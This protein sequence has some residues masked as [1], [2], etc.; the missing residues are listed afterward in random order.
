MKHK[1]LR[2]FMVC[3]FCSASM[4][5]AQNKTI[6]G[7]VTSREDGLPIPGATVKIQGT[8]SGGQTNSN[9][10]Y[11]LNV[12]AGSKLVFSFIGYTTQIIT[13]GT[14]TT[15]DV[16]LVSDAKALTEVVVTANAIVREKRSL[17]YSA[18]TVKADEL[19]QGGSSS[20]ISAL[21]GRVA[22][23]NI[24]SSSSTPGSSSRI[25]LRGGS[26]ISGNNQ[27]LIVV[28]GLPIDNSSVIGGG[29]LSS[30]DFGNRGNDINPDDIAS[31]TVLKGPAAAALYGSR[32]SNGALIITTKTGNKNA[33][34]TAITFNSQNTF[35]SILKLP[36]FQNEYGQGYYTDINDDGTANYFNDP[37]ENGS[38]GAP[39]TGKVQPWGQEIDGVQ[40]TKAYSAIKN[41]I[42]DFFTTGYAADNN[43]TFSGGT[44]KSTF[45]LGLNAVNSNGILPGNS[46]KFNKYGVRFNGNTNFSNKF[47][48][49]ISVN[50]NKTN[51]N[52][53]AGGQN[54]SS[55]YN[56]LL[57]TPRD[58]PITQLKDLNNKYNSFGGYVDGNGVS[59]PNT[60]GYYGAYTV[61]PYWVIQ[62]YKNLDDLS[63]IT[64]NVNLGY[65]P[66]SW[67]N[68]VERVGIDSYSER[69][70]FIAPKYK[71]TPLDTETGNYDATGNLQTSNGSYEIDQFNVTE[72]VH[73]LMITASHK[74]NEDFNGSFM[75]GNNIRQR[76]TNTTQTS[77]NTSNGLVVPDWYNLA[78]SNGPVNVITDNI[79]KQRLVGLYADLNLSYKSLIFLEA[80]ARND[81]SST[82]PVA[83]NSF[84]YP[85][86]SGS[87]VFSELLKGTGVDNVISYGK[88]R[89]SWAQV[90]NDTQPYQLANTF[91]R[92]VVNGSF[93]NTTFPF[94][95]V[96]A[97]QASNLIGNATLKPEK[98]SSFE[99]GTEL[100]FL[101]GRISADFSYYKNKSKNQILA[102]P[103]P[104]STG[105]SFAVVNAGEIQNRGVEASLRGTVVKTNDITWELFATYTKNNSK[106][107]SLLPG[108][109]QV[110]VGGFN[111]MS[112]VAAVG[113]PYGEFYAVTDQKD[114]Q[115]RTV[116]GASTGLPLA[117]AKAQYLGS[118]NPNY[119][120]SWGSNFRFKQLSLNVLFDTKQGGKLYSRTKDIIGFNGTSAETGGVRIGAIF[121]NS[122]YLQNGT[123]V[124]NTD[125]TYNKQDLYTSGTN[126][127]VNII[128]ATYIKLRSAALSYTFTKRQLG[129]SPFGA[130]TIGLYG[131]NLFLWT[132]K[133]NKF[134]DPEVN[135]SGAG[136]AQGFDFSAQPS[137]RNYGINVKVSF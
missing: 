2:I 88:L 131:N 76:E 85:S 137:V 100:G 123:Y 134:V 98:T 69:R 108:I 1:L 29:T 40:Q 124:P 104:N 67:L 121:P 89:S 118:Y 120:A 114:A 54:N 9:G 6:T 71:N 87:F 105:Y 117:T 90:G 83:N 4:A 92:T 7:T 53:I 32:A 72:F 75:I 25:V 106:V 34:K 77:T 115:G 42:R 112:I 68:V 74:F 96:A 129:R 38:W 37:R 125:V 39:F 93:G 65:K 62:N 84:F 43:L 60:Y 61:N 50:Y 23:V 41:N 63:R 30:I 49:G 80:T 12:P 19:T 24:T 28:D 110:V 70:R 57:Q 45:F 81:W 8:T 27:A 16:S 66:L 126:T 18:P 101:D 107:I 20:A 44:D 94:G 31:V 127:G 13:V 111:G 58:I 5:F 3:F 55:V 64:G 122:S 86:V 82:L 36:D 21:T 97:L 22:G 47:S 132:S 113:K 99:V 48:A 109:D 51:A 128:D 10:K 35:S 91:A 133:E 79:T 116:V 46:D 14:Q 95:N 17:G 59:H 52:E 11:S 33:E 136:N 73:D 102:I 56:N 15:I 26:S 130:L 119:Q 78:N 135:S 103:V